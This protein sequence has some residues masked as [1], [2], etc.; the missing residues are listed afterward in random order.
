[1]AEARR[2]TSPSQAT[3]ARPRVVVELA[4]LSL[5]AKERARALLE[6]LAF[7]DE[8]RLDDKDAG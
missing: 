3:P 6:E 1:V 8:P 4:G 7:A 5:A 2:P